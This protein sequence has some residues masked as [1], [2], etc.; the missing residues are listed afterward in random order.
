MFKQ[1]IAQGLAIGASAMVRASQKLT[2]S[3]PTT[4]PLL[5]KEVRKGDTVVTLNRALF[6][7]PLRLRLENYKDIELPLV[8]GH[9][10]NVVHLENPIVG[11]GP[12]L[13]GSKVGLVG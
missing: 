1:L 10:G 7:R 2:G 6:S 8:A 4:E 11:D 3:P 5:A 13:K 9:Y 12:Y